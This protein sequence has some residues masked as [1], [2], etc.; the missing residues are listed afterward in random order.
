LK[1][2]VDEFIKCSMWNNCQ[3]ANIEEKIYKEIKNSIL[4]GINTNEIMILFRSRSATMKNLISMLRKYKIPVYQKNK[5]QIE[6]NKIVQA[7]QL[8][9]KK[10]NC[11]T[12]NNLSQNK[13]LIHKIENV[14]RGT[15]F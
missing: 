4:S 7:I 2:R 9:N 1:K 14:P 3:K 13:T 15:F 11:S 6:S 10:I 12:W 5:N 8:I